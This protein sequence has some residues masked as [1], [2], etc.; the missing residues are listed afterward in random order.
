MHILANRDI[1]T[2]EPDKKVFDIFLSKIFLHTFF[3]FL[4]SFISPTYKC[5][6]IPVN[7]MIY[8]F[9]DTLS[10]L[11]VVLLCSYSHNDVLR[12]PIPPPRVPQRNV[13][14]AAVRFVQIRANICPSK[15]LDSVTPQP[16]NLNC[17]SNKI[18]KS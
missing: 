8:K 2:F 1:K 6:F 4:F 10:N 5:T 17:I 11:L 7:H 12:R 9:H 16:H 18:R 14:M 3:T 15:L 13:S